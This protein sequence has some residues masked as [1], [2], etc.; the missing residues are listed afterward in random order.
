MYVSA[1]E[2]K[3]HDNDNTLSIIR[4]QYIGG[5]KPTTLDFGEQCRVKTLMIRRN[6]EGNSYKVG[7]NTLLA[8]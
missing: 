7:I 5:F 2:F 1:G 6:D 8:N 3:I 4:H